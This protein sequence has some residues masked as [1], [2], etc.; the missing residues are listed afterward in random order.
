[1]KPDQQPPCA[2][3]GLVVCVEVIPAVHESP[4]QRFRLVR[5]VFVTGGW[6]PSEMQT[7]RRNFTNPFASNPLDTESL[8]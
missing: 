1:M 3:G 6:R 5:E 7:K 2:F 8:I 4:S